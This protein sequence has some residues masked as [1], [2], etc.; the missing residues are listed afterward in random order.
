MILLQFI[1]GFMVGIEW[2]E[3]EAMI[4]ADLGII[5]IFWYYDM[6]KFGV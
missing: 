6:S 1:T 5:R 4:V 2:C 3:N